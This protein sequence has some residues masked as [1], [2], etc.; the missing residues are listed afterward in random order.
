MIDL[1]DELRTYFDR[2]DPPF[3]PDQ[4]MQ[5]FRAAS[6]PVRIVTLRRGFA[7][8]VAAA[9]LAVGVIG[10]PLLFGGGA[11]SEVVDEATTLPTTASQLPTLPPL[12]G[13][14][15]VD[16]SDG[17]LWAWEYVGNRIWRYADGDWAELP[18]TPGDVSSVESIAGR[19]WANTEHGIYYLDGDAW[20]ALDE[21]PGIDWIIPFWRFAGD[22][23]SGDLWLS[24]GGRLFH[25]DGETITDVGQ[26]DSVEDAWVGDVAV[27][28]DGTL[29]A[30]GFYGYVPSIGVLAG[31][32]DEAASWKM[33]R[34][35]GDKPVPASVL[36]PTSNGGLWVVL[37]DWDRDQ[38]TGALSA[39]GWALAYRD[40]TTE[41][42]SVFDEG[43]PNGFPFA[44]APDD[45]A[46]WLAQGY[47]LNDGYGP[48]DGL[49]H[50]DGATWTHY[51]EGVE[52]LDVAVA[53]DG[54]VWYLADE[55]PHVLRPL[56]G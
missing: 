11:P 21:T 30:G 48:I 6:S 31:Y 1:G 12:E 25:W 49:Y 14:V 18:A 37:D 34:P 55:E 20:K 56:E 4:L 38:T 3:T 41:Q 35:W 47:A 52:V 50:F 28:T 33:V 16:A 29:W 8:A 26:P 36:A 24:T 23:A 27:T 2:V 5:G 7:I 9:F 10:L 43:L 17:Y 45:D 46:V 51:L 53:P 42:W 44:V 40:G 32:D 13:L 15:E 54:T 39:E 19:P 22:G